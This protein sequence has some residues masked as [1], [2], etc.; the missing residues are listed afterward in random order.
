MKILKYALL[1]LLVLAFAS[2]SVDYFENPNEP[3]IPTT[4]GLMNQVQQQF[5]TDTRGEWVSGRQY[6]LWM[7]YWNQ[8]NYT[9]EDRF[10]Y[11]ESACNL[12]AWND[13]Y[14][15]AQDLKS[16]IDL[17]TDPETASQMAVT[18]PNENQIS[19]ARIMLVYVYL[20]AVE[21]WGNVPYYSYGS[22]NN[23]FQ[24]NQ[25]TEGYD[26]VAYADQKDIY[27]D[28]LETLKDAADNIDESSL[29]I[30]GDNFYGGNATQWKRFANSLRLRIA[31]RIKDVYPAATD[32][33]T[34]AIASGVFES[35]AD[36]AGVTFE[37]NA[38]NGAPWFQAYQDR[39][40]FAPSVSFVEL[41]QGKRGNYATIDPR[42][43]IFVDD[44]E[45]GFKVGIPLMSNN[46]DVGTFRFE[47][48]PGSVI[49]QADFTETYMEYAEVCFLMSEINGWD[50]TWYEKGVRASMEKWGVDE[51][52]IET[53]IA[54]LPAANEENVLTQKY[55]ALYMQP[56]EAW[57]EYRRT[58]YPNHLIKPH[59]T[60]DY[61]WQFKDESGTVIDTTATYTFTPIESKAT[62]TDLPARNAYPTNEVGVNKNNYLAAQQAMGED[63]QTTKLWWAKK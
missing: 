51:S 6:L 38:T 23:T 11:R 27:A 39:Q 56:L 16:I 15:N 30:D 53:Y 48:N 33:I 17:N 52:D 46:G 14:V 59:E 45:D 57:S 12:G 49:L 44:N 4:G 43:A 41:L 18:A 10:Q 60:Y 7:Q 47:S 13:I 50:Q 26:Y 42:L 63:L 8:R 22:D 5:M 32:H 55:I 2:C 3:T 62:F 36:N 34:D 9:E 20:N 1:S 24:A 61:S 29:M 25:V 54:G 31:N 58:G 21:L 35:N 19:A 40:D 37:D 28:M